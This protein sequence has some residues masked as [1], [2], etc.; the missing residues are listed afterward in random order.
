VGLTNNVVVGQI[1]L[2]F[3][4]LITLPVSPDESCVALIFDCDGTLVDSAQV[5]L[6]GYNAAL[7]EYGKVMLWDWYSSRLGIPARDLLLIFAEEFGVALN[8][9]SSDDDLRERVSREPGSRQRGNARG[10][11]GTGVP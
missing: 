4:S 2:S 9:E 1:S 5:H 10:G 3:C 8:I 11:A 6:A 7:A